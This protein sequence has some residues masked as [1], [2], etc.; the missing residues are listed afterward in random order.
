MVMAFVNSEI[1]S[2]CIKKEIH[3]NFSKFIE[4][5][6]HPIFSHSIGIH[7]FSRVLQKNK[8]K[9]IKEIKIKW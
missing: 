7:P 3:C 5:F 2:W 6:I 1:A 8:K 4:F 9:K